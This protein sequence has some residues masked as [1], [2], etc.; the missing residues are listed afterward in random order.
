MRPVIEN[1]GT[2]GVCKPNPQAVHTYITSE[3]RRTRSPAP[4]REGTGPPT[5]AAARDK[6]HRVRLPRARG[7][8]QTAPFAC[9]S[10]V[11]THF[12]LYFCGV[13]HN[14]R[15]WLF[16]GWVQSAGKGQATF[17]CHLTASAALV[18]TLQSKG[19]AFKLVSLLLWAG[20]RCHFDLCC[21]ETVNSST[22]GR[23]RW[24]RRI[25]IGGQIP[26]S[27]ARFIEKL[28]KRI[29]WHELV[30][31]DGLFVVNVARFHSTASD[32]SLIGHLLGFGQ[33]LCVLAMRVVGK[34][35]CAHYCIPEPRLCVYWTYW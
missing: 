35:R 12:S 21:S 29:I 30:S 20:G 11:P 5:R 2:P 26:T 33:P 7:Q 17:P 18:H 28:R 25:A 24:C 3:T 10:C 14:L 27:V 4:Y 22:T 31:L 23:A 15:P 34:P 16:A 6:P 13:Q 32:P 9:R 19:R 8:R 1:D